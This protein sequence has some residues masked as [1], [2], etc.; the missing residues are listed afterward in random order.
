MLSRD[1]IIELL[2]DLATRLNSRGIHGQVFIVGGAAM[3]LAYQRE[4]S[5]RDVDAAFAPK[6]EVYAAAREVAIDR[7]LAL[8]W[9][10]DAAKGFM[11][12]PDANQTV[13][14]DGPGLTVS[15]ASPRY[16]FAM[17]AL[18]ARVER[19]SDDLMTLYKLCKFR[20]HV[21]ALDWLEHVY[22]KKLLQ[23]KVQLIIEELF[24]PGDA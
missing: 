6:N 14:F 15:I 1:D 5:T 21:E 9:L 20:S 18:A 23:P 3:T 22:P 24:G 2:G 19:D 10:N 12:G 17:K 8:D 13:L 16:L 11:P 7:G 4:R